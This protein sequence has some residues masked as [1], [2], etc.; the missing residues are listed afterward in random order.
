MTE[1][2]PPLTQDQLIS[3]RYNY[4]L[5]HPLNACRVEGCGFPIKWKDYVRDMGYQENGNSIGA[6]ENGHPI[7][8]HEFNYSHTGY[9]K[10]P[11]SHMPPDFVLAADEE[12]LRKHMA[13]SLDKRSA[14]FARWAE[15]LENKNS[16]PGFDR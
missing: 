7:E 15:H 2:K 9:F 13:E 5:E 6:C 10:Y 11:H 1:T 8:T 12:T 4:A 3:H 14:M 16:E